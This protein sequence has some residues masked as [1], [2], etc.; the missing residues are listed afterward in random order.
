MSN[1]TF[2]QKIDYF[3]TKSF[4]SKTPTTRQNKISGHSQTINEA[5]YMYMKLK[6]SITE[7]ILNHVGK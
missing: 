7:K 4:S 1:K 2:S 6:C 5:S 3:Q